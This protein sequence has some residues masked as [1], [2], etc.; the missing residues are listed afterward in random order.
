MTDP[1]GGF[2]PCRPASDVE[3]GELRLRSRLLEVF[4]EVRV[5]VDGGPVGGAA[6]I[7]DLVH[8]LPP[9]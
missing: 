6:G 9:F 7:G 2:A 4:E 5:L 3:E 1:C 8:D